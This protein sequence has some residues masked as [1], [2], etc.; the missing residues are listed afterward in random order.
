MK[1]MLIV[2]LIV[3]FFLIPL[4]GCD[5]YITEFEATC[6]RVQTNIRGELSDRTWV[7]F[8]GSDDS[9]RFKDLEYDFQIGHSYYVRARRTST[10]NDYYF[11]LLGAEEIGQ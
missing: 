10:L 7:T 1:R 8:S 5:S 11:E 3:C 9:F 2:I 6:T 4:I